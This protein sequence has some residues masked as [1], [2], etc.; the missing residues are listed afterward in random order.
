[1]QLHNKY[2]N[3]GCGTRIHPQ[4]T[5]IDFHSD[6]SNVRRVNLLAGFPFPANSFDAVYSSHVLEHF[7]KQQGNFLINEAYR[8]LRPGGLLRIVVPNLQGSCAE[9]LRIL[10]LSDSDPEKEKYYKWIII[11]LLDQMVRT[12]PSGE[13]GDM[14]NSIMLGD[15]EALKTYIRSRTQNTPW[16]PPTSSTLRQKLKKLTPQ[17]ISTK[18]VY[19]YLK[20]IG[21]LIPR[22]L[23]SMVYIDT[24]I[25]ERHRWMYDS[26]SLKMLFSDVGF[27]EVRNLK[28][29]ESG[30]DQFNDFCL[31][32]NSDGTPYKHNSVYIE[33]RK[34]C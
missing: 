25:G 7:D 33:G 22:Y 1:M 26:Y 14:S 3:F 28:Y 30:I 4:W 17:K 20:A 19:W 21:I 5:N 8:V 29:N 18:F 34:P 24:G 9:Y 11:E 23:R 13:M 27:G 15:D 31:D 12:K 10:D 6:N 2:L 32:C 16:S